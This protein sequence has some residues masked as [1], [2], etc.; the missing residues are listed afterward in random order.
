MGFILNPSWFPGPSCAVTKSNP[1]LRKLLSVYKRLVLLNLVSYAND[2][3]NSYRIPGMTTLQ[4]EL[5]PPSATSGVCLAMTHRSPCWPPTASR[6]RDGSPVREEPD[7]RRGQFPWGRTH[8]FPG[9]AQGKSQTE[10]LHCR[11]LPPGPQDSPPRRLKAP[12]GCSSLPQS[13]FLGAQCIVSES[14]CTEGKLPSPRG[15]QGPP[16]FLT[17]RRRCPTHVCLE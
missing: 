5:T 2:F 7:A 13:I 17:L 4:M 12:M 8:S 3:T 11:K 14:L 1:Y 16:A 10:P 9:R 15:S 6:G